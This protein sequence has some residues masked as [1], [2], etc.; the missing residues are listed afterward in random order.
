M[1]NILKVLFAIS[2]SIAITADD[3]DYCKNMND[4]IDRGEPMIIF[5]LAEKDLTAGPFCASFKELYHNGAINGK[6]KGNSNT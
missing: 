1:K 5:W 2:A 3:L 6:P 4:K